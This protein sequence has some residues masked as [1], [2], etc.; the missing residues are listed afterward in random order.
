MTTKR[1]GPRAP[2]VATLYPEGVEAERLQGG[3]FV[4]T[5][6]SH[7]MS[8]LIRFGQ[9]L[10]FKGE[11]TRFARWNHV[12]L[13]LDESGRLGEALSTGVVTTD[14]SKYTGTDYYVVEIECSEEDR[15]QVLEFATAVL[16][17]P[18]RTRYGW[19]TIGSLAISQLTGSRFIFGKI[20]TAI[21][22]GFVSEAL[23]RT[24]AI[25]ARPPAYMTPADLAEHYDVVGPSPG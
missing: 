6:G 14:I 12:A 22:S 25:F 20:G 7:V 19:W 10:R 23:V 4:L 2:A 3:Y 8:R 9:S 24:G 13:V 11:S 17:A 21:C 18:Q 15:R 1:P 5:H 16:T